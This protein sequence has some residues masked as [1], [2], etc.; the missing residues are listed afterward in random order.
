MFRCTGG[1]LSLQEERDLLCLSVRGFAVESEELEDGV[2][3]VAA[4]VWSYANRVVAGV[5]LSGPVSRFSR[6]RIET[7]L[8]PLV[9]EAG[10]RISQRLGSEVA[11][12]APA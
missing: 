7:E 5:G 10:T 8:V 2:L 6:E 9:K 12:A 1:S 4:P 11:A 3:G